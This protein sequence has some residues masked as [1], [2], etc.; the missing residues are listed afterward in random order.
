[1]TVPFKL[2]A[3]ACG[4]LG[5]LASP[6]TA[7][8]IAPVADDS[9]ATDGPAAPRR[10]IDAV[11]PR[12]NMFELGMFGG[13]WRPADDLELHFRNA[14]YRQYAPLSGEIGARVGYY[15]LRHFGLEGELAMMPTRTR[16]DQRAFVYSARAH[17]IV[18]L[19]LYRL[20]PFLAVGGGVLAVSSESNAVGDDGDQALTI[21]GGLK[22]LVTEHI[23]LRLDVRDTMS[24]KR[25]RTVND[26]ADS[27]EVLLGFSVML[28]PRNRAPTSLPPPDTDGDGFPDDKDQCIDEIGLAPEGCPIRDTDADGFSDD[29]DA[30]PSGPGVEPDGCPRAD[31]DGDGVIDTVDTCPQEPGTDPDGCPFL[32]E[33]SDGLLPPE[34]ACPDAAETVN[35]FEDTDGCPDEI[36]DEVERSPE[37]EPNG[38]D[39]IEA[40]TP[41]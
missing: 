27:I 41:P 10:W 19:G 29:I 17:A 33:D 7:R 14:P 4:A 35:G 22:Y 5:L 6:A 31:S 9:A 2:L 40:G 26:P 38:P 18:Q 32:D 28:G 13:L 39:A 34:D 36:P 16:T 15:P 11:A 25:G 37:P 3:G 20:V 30:C 21:G 12:R 1:M 24:P 8:A 23:Q